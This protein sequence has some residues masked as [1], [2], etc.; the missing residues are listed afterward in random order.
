MEANSQGSTVTAIFTTDSFQPWSWNV[1]FDTTAT[2]Q[3]YETRDAMF[4]KDFE[5]IT[6][7]YRLRAKGAAKHLLVTVQLSQLIPHGDLAL[8][9][10]RF[11]VVKKVAGQFHAFNRQ[12]GN[13][14]RRIILLLNEDVEARDMPGFTTTPDGTRR[15]LLF[16]GKIFYCGRCHSK[17]TFHE[18]FPSEQRDE[19]QQPPTEQ[20]K[21][22]SRI[23]L[24][25]PHSCIMMQKPFSKGTRWSE[26]VLLRDIHLRRRVMLRQHPKKEMNWRVIIRLPVMR[27]SV[28]GKKEREANKKAAGT[29]KE[30]NSYCHSSNNHREP[31]T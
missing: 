5:G 20:K 31:K 13:G 7:T 2:K 28:Q 1:I 17:H 3:I 6:Y 27:L 21:S 12:I 16:Q 9:F 18:S 8:F 10:R 22:N 14:L 30:G 19:K 15:K 26:T 25:L 11:G 4:A 29:T 24:K 23:S